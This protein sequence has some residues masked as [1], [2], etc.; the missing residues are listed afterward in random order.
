MWPHNSAAQKWHDRCSRLPGKGSTAP[1]SLEHDRML[2][3]IRGCLRIHFGDCTSVLEVRIAILAPIR[4]M[5][6]QPGNREPACCSREKSP[7]ILPH[8]AWRGT[9]KPSSSLF[10]RAVNCPSPQHRDE[11]RY[12]SGPARA[13]ASEMS[14][15]GADASASKPVRTQL[16]RLTAQPQEA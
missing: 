9:T 2:Q 4:P 8:R 12:S 11:L 5:W 3:A 15:P 1:S 6:Q 10:A 7:P 14:V 16:D 13:M